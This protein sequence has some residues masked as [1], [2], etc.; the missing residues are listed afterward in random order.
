MLEINIKN[1]AI[2]QTTLPFNSMCNVNG[3]T[4]GATGSGLFVLG[5]YNDNGSE[6]P[7]LLKSGVTDFGINNQKRFRFVHVTG[8]ANG[9]C[10]FKMFADGVLVVTLDI[11]PDESGVFDVRAP[12]SR[13]AV[14]RQ[15]QWQIENVDGAF[16]ALYS[17]E[18]LPV[19]LHPGRNRG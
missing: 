18:A 5:G 7:M 17:V 15:W 2:S 14:G 8:E 6:I 11:I 10:V 4:L 1:R 16:V 3:I 12:V 13:T 19:I 9:D